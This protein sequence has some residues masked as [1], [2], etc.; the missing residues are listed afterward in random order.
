MSASKVIKQIM[1]ETDTSVKD[2]AS[3]LGMKSSQVL[4]NKLYRDTFTFDDYIKIVGLMGC[5]VQTVISS[6]GKLYVNGNVPAD[7]AQAPE[8]P[9][10]AANTQKAD[11]SPSRADTTLNESGHVHKGRYKR[12]TMRDERQLDFE[13]LLIDPQYQQEISD[14]F[15]ADV[16]IA[17]VNR[18][19]KHQGGGSV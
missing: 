18:A 16:L 2:L 19:R 5:T 13:R 15:G 10:V 14:T 12:L 4:S 11:K 7:T 8:M 1:L 6:S 17:L 9:H 3:M